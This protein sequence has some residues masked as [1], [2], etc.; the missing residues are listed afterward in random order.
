MT[1]RSPQTEAFGS[2]DATSLLQCCCC[3]VRISLCVADIS[4]R[5]LPK[6]TAVTPNVILASSYITYMYVLELEICLI[7][8]IFSHV[9]LLSFVLYGSLHMC[10]TL[11]FKKISCTGCRDGPQ[12]FSSIECSSSNSCVL[13]N[14][15]LSRLR[16]GSLHNTSS[17]FAECE[18]QNHAS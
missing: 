7:I 4:A 1:Q 13:K 14:A 3:N 6:R 2:V 5:A 12:S 9:T 16:W 18:H 11:L 8:V 10:W 17:L 15:P